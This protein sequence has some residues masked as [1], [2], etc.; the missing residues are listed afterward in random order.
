MAPPSLPY[1]THLNDAMDIIKPSLKNYEELPISTNGLYELVLT[2]GKYQDTLY[3]W[4]A[5]NYNSDENRIKY[6]LDM[7]DTESEIDINRAYK[8][9]STI[10]SIL[11]LV[12]KVNLPEKVKKSEYDDYFE[13]LLI[14]HNNLY[15]NRLSESHEITVV[16]KQDAKIG[17]VMHDAW[18]LNTY[19]TNN[20]QFEY[21]YENATENGTRKDRVEQFKY[22]KDLDE[23][24]QLK[25]YVSYCCVIYAM[26]QTENI[27]QIIQDIAPK[28]G[29]KK[30][31]KTTERVNLPLP[32]KGKSK[33]SSVVYVC[34]KTKYVRKGGEWET[35]KKAQNAL[36]KGGVSPFRPNAPLP[37]KRP[38][39]DASQILTARL[40]CKSIHREENEETCITDRYCTNRYPECTS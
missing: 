1:G 26:S 25:D 17:E 20:S 40:N 33:R 34:G 28:T 24:E 32:G 21:N 29:G 2:I 15:T 16:S 9:I 11:Q 36:K 10:L 8:K 39:C 3:D 23:V 22:F 13:L 12:I 27:D 14:I 37:P 5:P 35:L 7:D 4:Y 18:A 31:L 19:F 38:C 30:M 6:L